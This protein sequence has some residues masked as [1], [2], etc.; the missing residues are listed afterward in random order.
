M[1]RDSRFKNTAQRRHLHCEQL[2]T[3]R[4][5]AVIQ[6]TTEV[7]VVDAGDGLVSMREAVAQA[8]SLAGTDTIQFD[9]ALDTLPIIITAGEGDFDLTDDVIIQGNGMDQ[10]ILDGAR[11]DRVFHVHANVEATFRDLT[12][13]RGL[14]D[15]DS[16]SSASIDRLGGGVLVEDATMTAERVFFFQ[17]LVESAFRRDPIGGGNLRDTPGDAYGGA[18]AVVGDATLTVRES[19]LVSN[20]ARGIKGTDGAAVSGNRFVVSGEGGDAYGGAVAALSNS[21]FSPSVFIQQSTLRANLASGG[22]GGETNGAAGALGGDAFGGAIY[23]EGGMLSVDQTSVIRNSASGGRGGSDGGNGF[24]GGLSADQ[25]DVDVINTSVT[26]NAARGGQGGFGDDGGDARGGGIN[27]VD[28]MLGLSNATVSLNTNSRGVRGTGGSFG[29]DLGGAGLF[30]AGATVDAVATLLGEN[31]AIQNSDVVADFHSS[32]SVLIQDASGATGISDGVDGNQLGVDPMLT[33]APVRSATGPNGFCHAPTAASPAIDSALVGQ[34]VDQNGVLRPQGLG[35]DIGAC[36]S[37]AGTVFVVSSTGDGGDSDLSDGVAMDANGDTTLRAAIEQANANANV[38]GRDLIAFEIPGPGPHT[39]DVAMALPRITDPVVIN[40]TSQPGFSGVPL[41]Q[42]DGA[43]TVKVGLALT[44]GESSVV[45]LSVTGFTRAGIDISSAR[46]AVTSS[47]VGVDPAGNAAPNRLGVRIQQGVLNELTDNVI[48]GNSL[49][50][51]R[52]QGDASRDNTLRDNK[53]GTDAAGTSALGNGSDGVTILSPE[54]LLDTNLISGNRRAGVFLS[55]TD[56]QRNLLVDNTIGTD[57]NVAVSIPNQTGVLVR[58]EDNRIGSFAVGN[59]ISGNAGVGVWIATAQGRN[60]SVSENVIGLNADGTSAIGNGNL[61]VYIHRGQAN[62]VQ[63]NVIS[64]NGSHGVL[65]TDRAADNLVKDNKIGTGSSGD[66]AIGNAGDGVRI[67]NGAVAND[68]QNN[69]VSG[70]L[71]RGI[72]VDGA[73]TTDNLLLFNSV[74]TTANERGPLH[75]GPGGGIRVLAPLTTANFNVVSAPDI[76]MIFLRDG[77]SATVQSN[78]IGLDRAGQDVNLG[79]PVGMRFAGGT[80]SAMVSNNRIANVDQGIVV[81]RGSTEI[82][83]RDNILSEFATIGIDLGNDGITPND[84]GDADL[85][86]NRLQNTPVISRA[87]A[88]GIRIQMIYTIDTSP[89]H[90]AYPL[91]VDFFTIADDNLGPRKI[92]SSTFEASDFGSDKIELINQINI[93]NDAKIVATAM[94]ANG[95]TSEFSPRFPVFR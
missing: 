83:I 52:I 90:A 7:D 26:E 8:N 31:L 71:A 20:T 57:A 92:G 64:G 24:G 87:R 28:G 5:L 94:D 4:L 62:D 47:Y 51:V 34:G 3:R 17:N 40:A 69:Q 77:D 65:L 73:S 78:S 80:H 25:G 21:G 29:L 66:L 63:R 13:Q 60:N 1:Q 45:G 14:V 55:G 70:N 68:I 58:S 86:A 12:I 59:V 54:T 16:E 53:I 84:P 44:S 75:N 48:S 85:G 6:V 19:L 49:S 72:T 23:L 95:N 93:D 32:N 42:V 41:V 91:Q 36:E 35:F 46:N 67:V 15:L 79:V 38:D 43:N 89:A 39:I 27:V 11:V 9:S 18:V 81:D 37:T 61:G 56:A 2:E 22:E 74:G 76:A 88:K 50:G 33:P 10:T 30:S 82:A